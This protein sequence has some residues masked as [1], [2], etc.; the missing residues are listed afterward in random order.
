MTNKLSYPL[1]HAYLIGGFPKGCVPTVKDQLQELFADRKERLTTDSAIVDTLL[2]DMVRSL[3]RRGNQRAGGEARCSV[4]GFRSATREA[5]NTLL[6]TL[7]EP[8][9]GVHLFLVM[10]TPGELLET[11]RSRTTRADI[12]SQ[13]ESASSQAKEFL[14]AES[15]PERLHIAQQVAESG[16]LQSFV[17]DLSNISG[18]DRTQLRLALHTV[19]GWLT[20]TGHSKTQ[21]AE[22]L[23]F[24]VTRDQTST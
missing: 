6:K 14:S 9:E 7:E 3:H 19:A 13:S 10:P 8:A 20:D 11:V 15:L 4:R 16:D 24:A 21:I 22:F 12:C 1:A 17:V 5:Q 18:R 23:A 2:I